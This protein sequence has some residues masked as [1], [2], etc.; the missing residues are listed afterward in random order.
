MR[1]ILFIIAFIFALYPLQINAQDEPFTIIYAVQN[2][3][4]DS[5]ATTL[6]L[7]VTVSYGGGEFANNVSLK[8]SSPIGDDSNVQGE[9]FIDTIESGQLKAAAA[10]FS[11]PKGFFDGG[12]ID[13]LIWKAT[14]TDV[15][16]QIQTSIIN[17]I[18]H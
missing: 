8:L 6:T 11:A 1:K 4:S 12:I 16:G 17:G 2:I 18:K 14:Y 13:S 3:S 5:V 9:I 15:R 7:K 10:T